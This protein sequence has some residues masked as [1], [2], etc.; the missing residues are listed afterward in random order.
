[1]SSLYFGGVTS[2]WK[3]RL[4]IFILEF[5]F[6]TFLNSQD[7]FSNLKNG[8][9]FSNTLLHSETQT[10][11]LTLNSTHQKHPSRNL[12]N[13]SQQRSESLSKQ[14]PYSG[15]L[16]PELDYH[17][18]RSSSESTGNLNLQKTVYL[19][20]YSAIVI[21][22]EALLSRSNIRTTEAGEG[23]H[24][25]CISTQERDSIMLEPQEIGPKRHCSHEA[26]NGKDDTEGQY[27][28]P[29]QTNSYYRQTGWS[30]WQQVAFELDNFW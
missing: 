17:I 7:L 1:M 24:E 6:N 9:Y 10:S 27:S 3:W 23:Q 21:S 28:S 16:S 12:S 4:H 13:I 8:Q 20:W 19:M 14:I 30:W 15:G 29:S 26:Y 18:G 25:T 22:P 5:I 11:L 2:N